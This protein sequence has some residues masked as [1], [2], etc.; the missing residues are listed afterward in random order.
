MKRKYI[1]LI[2]CCTISLL[3][4][5]LCSNQG[6]SRP[7]SS[8]DWVTAEKETADRNNIMQNN[9]ITRSALSD[10]EIEE[11]TKQSR[12]LQDAEIEG[13]TAKTADELAEYFVRCQRLEGAEQQANILNA[14]REKIK[15]KWSDYIGAYRTTWQDWVLTSSNG[16]EYWL[17]GSTDVSFHVSFVHRDGPNGEILYGYYR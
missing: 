6:Q 5:S 13:M 17:W 16:T 4:F 1:I 15:D 10:S 14:R 12:F 9:T 2:A 8:S 11:I 3:F 7:R